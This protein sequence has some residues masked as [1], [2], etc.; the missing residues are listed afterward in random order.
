MSAAIYKVMPLPT[1]DQEIIVSCK[2]TSLMVYLA[3]HEIYTI[4][5]K[6]R[7]SV[8]FFTGKSFL[9]NLG[10]SRVWKYNHMSSKAI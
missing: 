4:F 3:G 10:L 5:S 8:C 2:E 9:P 7:L 6:E 1:L